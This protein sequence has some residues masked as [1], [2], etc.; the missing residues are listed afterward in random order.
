MDSV[1]PKIVE[2]T[3]SSLTGMLL[4]ATPVLEGTSFARTVI[5]MCAH[6][7][8]GG[9]MGL[10]VNRRLLRPDLE[11]LLEQLQIKPFPPIRRV[12]L[13]SGGPVNEEHGFV[14]HSSD[15]NGEESIRVTE[16]MTLTASK[17]ILKEI[18]EGNGPQDAL[19][20]MGH[21]GWAAGQ[22]EEEILK[23]PDDLIYQKCFQTL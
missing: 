7:T 5:Y 13:F 22:L 1:S 2:K 3:M 17:D 4:V 19:L 11:E 23:N 21:S 10:V 12:G 14:L 18:A 6:T 20:V 8:D 15:W 16:N 9:A